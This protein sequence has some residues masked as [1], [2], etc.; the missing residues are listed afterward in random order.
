MKLTLTSL[1]AIALTANAAFAE[2]FAGMSDLSFDAAWHG[3]AVEGAVWYPTDGGG[4]PELFADNPVFQ[5]VDVLRDAPPQ[6]GNHPVVLFSHGL[7]GNIRSSAWLAVGL[8]KRGAIVVA[9]DHP[10]STT[11]DFDLG[12]GLEHG[13]RARDLSAALDWLLADPRFAGQLNQNQIMAAGFSYGGWT[14]LSLGGATAN[15]DAYAAHCAEALAIS[16]HCADI[17]N[18]GIKLTDY[19]AA[20]WNASYRDP[21]VTQV[22]AI[23]P[24]LIWGLTPGNVAAL[25]AKVLLVGLG[26]GKDRLYETDFTKSGFDALVPQARSVTLAPAAHYSAVL[27]CKP[28]GAAILADEGEP[29]PICTDP[30]GTDRKALHEGMIDLFATELGL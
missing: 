14:A 6:A 23:D 1:V 13:T 26:Q 12:P 28:D 15:R 7:G 4:A 21:R 25:P 2:T 11:R 17:A 22:V 20:T 5:G 9:V 24:A 19:D 30:E 3:R 8:A 18:A 27:L 16:T 10:N 29:Y